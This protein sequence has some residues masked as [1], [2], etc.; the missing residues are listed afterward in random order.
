MLYIPYIIEFLKPDTLISGIFVIVAA[1]F[2]GVFTLA[3]AFA[4]AY[5][6]GQKTLQSINAQINYDHNKSELQQNERFRK[7]TSVIRRHILSLSNYY[8]QL[9]FLLIENESGMNVYGLD[10]EIEIKNE[11]NNIINVKNTLDNIEID[12]IPLEINADIQNMLYT[13]LELD[14]Y[15]D[16]YLKEIDLEGKERRVRNIINGI[17]EINTL[18]TKIERFIIRNYRVS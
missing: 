14:S 10:F 6:A 8:R 2:G 16:T 15:F 7:Y 18:I 12:L 4:G 5:L 11:L 17:K 1:I 3:G 9:H 13:I